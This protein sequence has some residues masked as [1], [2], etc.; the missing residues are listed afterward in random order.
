MSTY[1]VKLPDVGEGVAEAE[2][3]SW[4][5]QVGDRVTTDS[6]IAEVMTDKATVEVISP[7]DGVVTAIA[8]DPGDVLAV[9]GNL[10]AVELDAG[11]SPPSAPA[12]TPD[13]ANAAPVA[14]APAT[15]APVDATPVDATRGRHA[16]AAPAVRARAAKLG[17]DLAGVRGG[18]PDGRV[19]HD[20]L[21]RLLLRASGPLPAMPEGPAEEV[22]PLRGVRRRIAER[23]SQAWAQIPHITYVEAVDVTELEALR[24]E[25]IRREPGNRLTV[26]PFVAR[27]VVKACAEQPGLNAHLT[28]DP[29]ALRLFPAVHLGV[30]T[31]TDNGLIVPVVRHAERLDV[32]ELADEITRV[33]QAA[34]SGTAAREELTGS[35]ITITSLGAIGGLVTTPIINQPEVAIVG[36]NRIETRP[37]WLHQS[38]QPRQMLNLSSSFDHR[39]VDGW[40]AA[41]FVQRIK[42]YLEFPALL[43]E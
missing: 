20:D 4:L 3:I 39:V 34:R 23:M 28:E 29:P 27:A 9:G 22:V 13:P 31:Q 19:E 36:V 21:D 42:G 37:V 25:L 40:D 12:A 30:A 24:R 11:A 26:L 18:G 14:A 16:V 33:A 17:I 7:V 5:V 10:I 6:P 1:E 43:F 41:T 35:T 32:R 2:L 38:F 8:C 15:A